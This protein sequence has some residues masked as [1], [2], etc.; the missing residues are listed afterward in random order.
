MKNNDLLHLLRANTLAC[1]LVCLPAG[2]L[3]GV[4]NA[5]D[6]KL[7]TLIDI[8][9]VKGE[10]TALKDPTTATVV[11]VF[12][13]AD[14]K[15]VVER[16]FLGSATQLFEQKSEPSYSSYCPKGEGACDDEGWGVAL[17]APRAKTQ[18][19]PEATVMYN[20]AK[21]YQLF[22]SNAATSLMVMPASDVQALLKK[23]TFRTS[24]A[25]HR[26]V[27]LARDE[28]GIY[29]FVDRLRDDLGGQGYRVYVGKRG[30][31]KQM[32]LRDVAIDSGGMVFATKK[33]EFRLTVDTGTPT[34]A[35]WNSKGKARTLKV[36]D[37]F[38]ESYLIYRELGVYS[39]FGAACDEQ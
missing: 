35:T 9:S 15:N 13:S 3:A 34:G 16:V 24:G 20:Q 14:G 19:G 4:P 39:A 23:A 6:L 26:Q 25:V 37:L 38:T 28:A 2:A 36:L 31:L 12:L 8:A 30:A 17:F 21:N 10:L 18:N 27:A 1:A 32:P 11:L 5:A 29:Y 33:G 7:T 22:C